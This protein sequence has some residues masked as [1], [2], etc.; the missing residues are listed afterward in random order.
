MKF[1]HTSDWHLGRS[2]Y[3][4][5]RYEEFAAFLDWLA[6]QIEEQCV[7]ALLVVGDIF[8]T[9]TPSNQAQTLYYRFLCKV[10][11]S[12]CRNIVVIA[13]NHDSPTFLNAP[14]ELLRTMNVHV[15]GAMTEHP[16]DEIIVLMDKQNNPEAIVCAIPYL[17][18][19]DIRTVEAGETLEDKSF[20]LI[21]G[22]RSHYADVC[23]IAEQKQKQFG[24]IPIVALG[25]LFTAGGK[26]VEGDGVRDLYIGSLAHIHADV[27]PACVD[28][29]AL[30]HLH[31]AQLVGAKDH[32]RYSGS[33]IPM[34]FGEAN[35]EKKVI[36]VDLNAQ[37]RIIDELPIPCFQVLERISGSLQV[38]A[39]RID[40]LK[41]LESNA[42][43]EIVY[44]GSDLVG[45]LRELMEDALSGTAMEIR[46]IKN[47]ML[48]DRVIS[49]IND[50]ETL[51]DLDAHDVFV[52]CLDAFDVP[53][54]E[55][56]GMIQTYNEVIS[57]LFHEDKN[58]A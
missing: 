8:D 1:L 6:E 3:G 39:E 22:L 54:E 52:R 58:S 21:E 55:R 25:H 15:I 24:D 27:F 32:L 48:T 4:R 38:I 33:P 42:W 49:R 45:N 23:A 13:G 30:G 51:D 46:R 18:D 16:E 9:S 56:P 41:Q 53:V 44:T 36:L 11:N 37:D 14:K 20:K 35:Q 50:E 10:A 7:D 28:Y 29:L 40:E 12:C 43:L 19:K 17:R 47:R 26:I 57:D 31:V 2:L 34:G 5:R